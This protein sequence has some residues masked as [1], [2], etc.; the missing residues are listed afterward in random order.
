MIEWATMQTIKRD[1]AELPRRWLYAF[2]A[3]HPEAVRKCGAGR[4]CTRLLRVP[5]VLAAVDAGEGMGAA[6]AEGEAE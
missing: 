6:C 2:A 5:A 3:R 1:V 4:T